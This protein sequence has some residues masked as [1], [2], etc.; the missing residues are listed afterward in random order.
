MGS[1]NSIAAA[2][3]AVLIFGS[4][5]GSGCASAPSD[6]PAIAPLV[7]PR[8]PGEPRTAIWVSRWDYRSPG[9]IEGVMEDAASL[10]VTDVLWQ[11]RGEFDAYYDSPI[12]PWG[13]AVSVSASGPGFDPLALAIR[14][15]HDRGL[16]LHAWV[17]VFTLWRGY[18]EPI[19]P[20]H[21]L[22]E[23][24]GWAVYGSDGKPEPASPGYR[25]ANPS[26]DAVQDHVIAVLSDLAGRYD[27]DG[28]HLDQLRFRTM[29]AGGRLYPGDTATLQRFARETGV[30]SIERPESRA[31]YRA[32]MR[33]RITRFVQRVN[34]EVATDAEIS[35]VALRTPAEARER[36]L[37][38]VAAWLNA[39]LIDHIYPRLNT[40][41]PGLFRDAVGDWLEAVPADRLTPGAGLHLLSEDEAIRETLRAANNAG[42]VALF[43]YGAVFESADPEQ[44]QTPA[45]LT[46][47]LVRR[48]ALRDVLAPRT[49]PRTTP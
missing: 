1:R 30:A 34:A 46:D 47:R 23:M 17:N 43:A 48:Q 16:R 21:P 19:D 3:I 14:A 13:E 44:P 31:A 45:D 32:W 11:V 28:L 22:R 42:G 27:L 18:E 25:W 33:D 35:V 2:A 24:P 10:G 36:A 7:T 39:G 20:R 37:Q 12:E 38:D 5:C 8:A 40:P 15:A 29:E 49:A 9:D 26:L 4:L 41:E 6:E